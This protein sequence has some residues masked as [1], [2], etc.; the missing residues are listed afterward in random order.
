[1]EVNTKVSESPERYD[2]IDG[3]RVISA[4]G[5]VFMH[6]GAN[7]NFN[8]TNFIYTNVI[9]RFGYFVY[10]FMMIS[11]FSMCCGYYERLQFGRVT[12]DKYFTRRYEK[13]FPFFCI[14][15][16]LDFMFEPSVHSFYEAVADL[17]L[18]FSL[19]PNP[20]ITVIGVGWTLGV[21]FVFYLLF[22]FFITMLGNTKRIVIFLLCSIFYHYACIFYFFDE[23]HIGAISFN[24]GSNILYCAIY[25]VL[26]GLIYKYRLFIKNSRLFRL[27]I[28]V[29]ILIFG[30]FFVVVEISRIVLFDFFGMALFAML[31]CFCVS[32]NICVLNNRVM[33][34][35][36]SISMEIYLCH[37]MVF[38]LLE[39]MKLF[40]F[41]NRYF[42]GWL[43]YLCIAFATFSG[44]CMISVIGKKSIKMLKKIGK[45]SKDESSSN[46]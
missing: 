19:L 4:I 18:V 39:K 42:A 8:T 33:A 9:G 22:P 21:I 34:F 11:A 43:G 46:Y 45:G 31:L 23:I 40:D 44:A 5:I 12:L 26:G 13:V 32:T 35:L 20:N 6:V 15:V 1:M 28:L 27:I 16:L 25:F 29:G 37:M 7:I 10:L 17:S 14:L 3:L 38:R 24:E 2:S 36:S 30:S 41:V